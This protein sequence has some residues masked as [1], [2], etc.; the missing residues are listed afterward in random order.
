[1]RWFFAKNIVLPNP[2]WWAVAGAI[3]LW[4]R[5]KRLLPKRPEPEQVCQV[6]GKSIGRSYWGWCSVEC[7]M[8]ITN[9]PCH[10]IP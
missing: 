3:Y 6:C 9:E 10:P 1:M 5:F 7:L 4:R 2:L 8:E